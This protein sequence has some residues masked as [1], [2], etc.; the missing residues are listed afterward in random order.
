MKVAMW[1]LFGVLVLGL[2]L[3]AL[4]GL[5]I[6]RS[7]EAVSTSTTFRRAPTTSR[8][9][10]PSTTRYQ[11]NVR[12]A[13]TATTAT[14]AAAGEDACLSA[15][16]RDVDLTADR[17][18]GGWGTGAATLSRAVRVCGTDEMIAWL[19]LANLDGFCDDLW[20][21][22]EYAD[23]GSVEAIVYWEAGIAC[24]EALLGS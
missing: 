10:L 23:V 2:G 14:T 13:T 8:P 11:P 6:D 1:I 22:W 7:D 9:V 18:A 20:L 5:T 19:A 4:A 21:V 15:L 24:D 16:R 3:I 12:T 17:I